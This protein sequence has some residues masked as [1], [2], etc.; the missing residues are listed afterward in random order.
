MVIGEGILRIFFPVN[1]YHMDMRGPLAG[2]TGWSPTQN[3]TDGS[4]L[5]D[6]PHDM[7]KIKSKI[8]VLLVG[9]S[10]LD[11]NE[12]NQLFQN[13]IP[14]ILGEK[15]G[16]R[17]EVINLSAGGWGTDQEYLAYQNIGVKY[18]P[19]LVILFYTP[20]NDLFNNSSSKALYENLTKPRFYLND[21]EELILEESLTMQKE[22]SIVIKTLLK[23][24]LGKRILLLIKSF[25]KPNKVIEDKWDSESFAHQAG[26]KKPLS[27]KNQQSMLVTQK[28]LEKFAKVVSDK[29]G[30]FAIF[31]LP[32]G[33]R[34]ICSPI[35]EFP[36][37][38]VGYTKKDLTLNCGNLTTK[39]N[40]FHQYDLLK[41]WSISAEIP[42]LANLPDMIGYGKKH[43]LLAPDCIH[44]NK[45]GSNMIADKV[46]KFIS[47]YDFPD[48][49][50]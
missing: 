38:C 15:L 40:M 17:Y 1:I 2:I 42:L 12:R 27:I 11:C 25:K 48:R 4:Y 44:L 7:D 37:N 26:Y 43:H 22:K 10:V 41:K 29:E 33:M 34:N 36:T 28:I 23:T 8:R 31:Y 49:S 46:A 47:I 13:T 3:K 50:F 30:K 9:D 6:R 14:F 20:A 21:E 18:S 45:K 24:E 32:T 39:I 16:D 5:C 19:D 35:K